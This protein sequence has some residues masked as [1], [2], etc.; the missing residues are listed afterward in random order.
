MIKY[1]F[2]KTYRHPS[3]DASLTKARLAFEARSLARC[4]RAGVT[5]PTVLWVDEAHGVLGME[6]VEGWSI[7]EVLGGGAEGEA[8][9][10]DEEELAERSDSASD[11]AD[12]VEDEESEGTIALRNA[13]RTVEDLM[14]AIGAALAKL[15]LT[16]IIHGDLTTSNMMLRLTPHH[17]SEP[18]EIVSRRD[19][20]EHALTRRCS[21]TSDCPPRRNS[22]NTSL[23]TCTSLSGHSL[24]HIRSP[25]VSMLG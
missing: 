13:G 20:S 11:Q 4:A 19:V 8:Q 16:N 17:P 15:H 1:R 7:R 23:W 18:Y 5:V 24:P 22:Q 3:L 12:P 14:T 25:K 2:P 21:S 9:E 6:K 10:E